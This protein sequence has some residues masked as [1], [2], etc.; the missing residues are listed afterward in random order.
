MKEN[1][2]NFFFIKLIAFFKKDLQIYLSY[3]I[4]IISNLIL[5]FFIFT[6]FFYISSSEAGK[7]FTSSKN[8]L[9]DVL[10]AIILI[11]FMLVF[12]SV[13][14]NEVRTA[15]LQ[16][17]FEALILTRTSIL[18]IILSAYGFTFIKSFF[19]L[20]I[21]IL[22]GILIFEIKID[23]FKVPL[24]MILTIYG[25]IPFIALGIISAS[26]VMIFKVGN[27]VNLFIGLISISLSGIFFPIELFPE[28]LETISNYNPMKHSLN[29][30]QKILLESLEITQ[31]KKEIISIAYL[32]AILIPTSILIV[33][34]SL[35][36]SKKNG[37]LNYY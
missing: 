11:D 5:I 22:I 26:F 7:E 10:I 2:F 6:I 24:F 33:Y 19:R 12:V 30:S 37:N 9:G 16:G 32:I 13:F 27:I 36:F 28:M 21:Y 25:S 18:T 14:S 4:N 20:F 29:A 34:Y 35:R 17:T 3:K 23:I 31:I 1:Y 8:L 15:Q